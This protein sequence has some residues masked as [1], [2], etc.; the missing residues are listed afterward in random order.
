MPNMDYPGPCPNCVGLDSCTSD[1][2]KNESVQHYC[3]GLEMELNVWKS[4]L[5]DVLVQSDQLSSGNQS[6]LAD[7]LSLIKST[8][9]ELES[10]K[11]QMLNECPNLAD[12]ES[13]IGKG[14][15]NLR[16]NYTKALQV[17]SPGWFGG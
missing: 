10:L 15:E 1:E 12:K 14:F 5:Y 2:M 16:V 13:E 3:Q 9:R 4:R 7:T 6:E 8:V 17:I 11:E